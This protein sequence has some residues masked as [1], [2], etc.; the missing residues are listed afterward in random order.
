MADVPWNNCWFSQ[1]GLCGLPE[2]V[3]TDA[4]CARAHTH[5]HT[6]TRARTH[7]RTH[8]RTDART[9][10]HT[11][12]HTHTHTHRGNSTLSLS[13]SLTEQTARVLLWFHYRCHQFAQRKL[14]TTLWEC[15]TR[16]TMEHFK[17]KSFVFDFSFRSLLPVNKTYLEEINLKWKYT[18]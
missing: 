11:H 17:W 1:N 12:T 16:C 10:A 8:G 5:T 7:A 15:G 2:V 4:T 3:Q 13:L 14:D 18:K 9:R 6:H